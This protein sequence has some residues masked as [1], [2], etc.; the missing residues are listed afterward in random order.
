MTMVSVVTCVYNGM[1]YLPDAV[2]S[3]LGQS[4]KDFQYIVVDDGSTDGSGEYLDSVRDGRL[5]VVHQ[6]NL[7]FTEAGNAGF[8]LCE[9]ELVAIMDADDIALPH[10]LERQ[11]AFLDAHPDV[12]VVGGLAEYIGPTGRRG[13]LLMVP[14]EHERIVADLLRRGIGVLNPTA[15]FR[16]DAVRAV[17]GFRPGPSPD[18]DLFLRLAETCRLANLPQRLVLYRLH[19]ASEMATNMENRQLG[20]LYNV[21]CF[22][23]RKVGR[24]EP[25]YEEF[26]DRVRAWAPWK[27][28]AWK[29]DV[30]S[31]CE[32]RRG[33]LDV[34]RGRP[35]RGALRLAWSAMCSPRRA[36]RRVQREVAARFGGGA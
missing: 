11:V 26:L 8:A 17:G 31:L 22:N 33:L 21:E 10:R 12:S 23:R 9:G 16:M 2:R 1:P 13:P 36:M 24:P 3:V 34:V 32:H 18:H 28:A 14:L 4:R 5:T 7:G 25:T 35:V 15:C 30:Y 19:P 27:R 20:N 29:L 6:E